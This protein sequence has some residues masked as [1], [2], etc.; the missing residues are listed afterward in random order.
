MALRAVSASE[1][2][3]EDS[4]SAGRVRARERVGCGGAS[5]REAESATAGKIGE[6]EPYLG[7]QI[8]RDLIELGLHFATSAWNQQHDAED[9]L[10]W[11][12]DQLSVETR[13]TS[14]L[15]LTFTRARYRP[16][17]EE[18]IPRART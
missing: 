12:D 3:S 13:G 4:P 7:L 14:M 17:T 15:S 1:R 9:P 18:V 2:A 10:L 6:R 16:E 11:G 5:C 8:E